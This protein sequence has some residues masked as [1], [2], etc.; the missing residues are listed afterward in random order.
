MPSTP[1]YQN[2]KITNDLQII[3]PKKTQAH[4]TDLIRVTRS[5]GSPTTMTLYK[6]GTL[7][8]LEYITIEYPEDLI[9][10]PLIFQDSKVYIYEDQP[11]QTLHASFVFRIN[12]PITASPVGISISIL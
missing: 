4:V 1:I 2:L 3:I 6:T 8:A 9:S 10:N 5:F 12:K 11:L 7:G